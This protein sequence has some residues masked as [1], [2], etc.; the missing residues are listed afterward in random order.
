MASSSSRYNLRRQRAAATAPTAGA[1]GP[2]ESITPVT[3]LVESPRPP[4]VTD[5][6]AIEARDARSRASTPSTDGSTTSHAVRRPG[7][8][9]SQVAS[10]SPTA[11]SP[12]AS[13]AV[14]GEMMPPPVLSA[15]RG[16]ATP[17]PAL[18]AASGRPRPPPVLSTA[19]GPAQ[20]PPALSAERGPA[21]PSP[22]LSAA[23][24]MGLVD[25]ESIYNTPFSPSEERVTE[26]SNTARP[27]TVEEVIDEDADGPWREVRY[28]RRRYSDSENVRGA[29]RTVNWPT[30]RLSAVQLHAVEQ[31]QLELSL[32]DRARIERR[33]RATKDELRRTPSS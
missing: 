3:P 23:R 12:P 33:A 20:P 1:A 29:E 16:P 17:P 8:T 5:Q 10:A 31:A 4:S 21:P 11:K 6:V 26:G 32:S 22:A 30:R 27:V 19:S 18:S 24:V 7:V 25:N 28:G 9:Y 15:E 2:G 14:R 13:T